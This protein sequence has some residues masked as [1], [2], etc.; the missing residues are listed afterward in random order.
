[1]NHFFLSIEKL[2]VQLNGRQVLKEIDLLIRE[3]EQWAVIG[4]GGSG[5]TVL[6]H[7]ICGQH[8][9]TGQISTSFASPENFLHQVAVVEQQHRFRDITNRNDFYYQ[10]RYN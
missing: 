2:S 9:F 3:G 8:F 7:T 6:I 5:K 1:M 4:P 10:Q